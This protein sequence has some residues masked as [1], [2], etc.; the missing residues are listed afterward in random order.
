LPGAAAAPA[1]AL[2]AAAPAGG[3]ATGNAKQPIR[4]MLDEWKQKKAVHT[5]AWNEGV[6]KTQQNFKDLHEL[7][8]RIGGISFRRRVLKESMTSLDQHL[9]SLDAYHNKLEE[10]LNRMEDT[11]SS[12][13]RAAPLGGG[14][15]G[16][17]A[18]YDGTAHNQQRHGVY[19]LAVDLNAQLKTMDIDL[20]R[21]VRDLNEQ[22]DL[23]SAGSAA[24]DSMVENAVAVLNHH[25]HALEW[26]DRKSEALALRTQA[27]QNARA[28]Q[29][30]GGGAP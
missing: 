29:M 20:D 16:I 24:Q 9:Q 13:Q 27:L 14:F 1:F 22:H 28:Q 2:N 7:E 25:Y 10:H 8:V 23:R 11:L 15:G 3:V 21:L 6:R 26:V 17:G 18:G 5:N 30:G 12:R 4:S 19:D